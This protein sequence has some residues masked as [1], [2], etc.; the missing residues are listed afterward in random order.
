MITSQKTC[1]NNDRNA[2]AILQNYVRFSAKSS[3]IRT[4]CATFPMPEKGARPSQG[5]SDFVLAGH[6]FYWL[7]IFYMCMCTLI[8]IV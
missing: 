7:V 6:T 4:S 8:S 1:A 5:W 2:R 3:R